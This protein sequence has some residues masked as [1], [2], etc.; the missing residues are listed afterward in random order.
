MDV[1]FRQL[2]LFVSLADLKSISAVARTFHITQPTVSMQIRNL[3]DSIGM[4][5]HEV[6][7]KRIFLTSAGEELARSAR[8]MMNDWSACT[9]RLQSLQGLTRGQLKLAVVSTAKYFI[10]RMLGKFCE[11]F[12]EVDISLEVLNRDRIVERLR[13]NLDDLFI[14]SRPPSDLDVVLREFLPNP[15]VVIAPLSHP[16]ANHKRIK[17]H[18]LQRER[19]IVREQGSGTRLATNAFFA[20]HNFK[21]QIRMELGS[22]EAIKQA[23]AGKM[24]IAVLSSHAIG[25]HLMEEA[26]TVLPVVGFPIHTNWYIVTLEGKRLSPAATAFLQFLTD[27]SKSSQTTKPKS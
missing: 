26:L 7:G 11:Q 9:A 13:E 17:L 16:L 24:G 2:Q 4:P 27:I 25:T 6:I 3:A 22:N 23:V 1:T 15:L 21:P 12:P 10:P 8:S 19:F 20:E 18:S 14:M 5:L